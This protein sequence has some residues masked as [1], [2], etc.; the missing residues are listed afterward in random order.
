M[1][2]FVAATLPAKIR[3]AL[4]KIQEDFKEF[5]A[6][7]VKK[8]NLHITVVFIG[9][10]KDPH[11]VKKIS[12]ALMRSAEKSKKI[13]LETSGTALFPNEHK[14][15][16]LAVNLAGETEALQMLA[17]EIKQRLREEKINFDEKILHPHITIARLKRVH[18]RRRRKIRQGAAEY[19]APRESF[20][21]DQIAL[22]ESELTAANPVYK[23]IETFNLE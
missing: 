12:R 20:E 4:A 8:E 17:E 3:E 13:H 23:T 21:V 5:P 16:V 22:M 11:C 19:E 1:R 10:I 7:W 2:L 18:P 14:A 9:E 15:R 6:R